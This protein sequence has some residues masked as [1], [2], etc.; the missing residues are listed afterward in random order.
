MKNKSGVLILTPS[1]IDF[2]TEAIIR[3]QKKDQANS[4]SEFI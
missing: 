1:Q 2:N 3:D 4:T